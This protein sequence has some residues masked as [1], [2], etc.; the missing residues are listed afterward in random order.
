MCQNTAP[1]PN[2]SAQE[3][4]KRIDNLVVLNVRN[5][6]GLGLETRYTELTGSMEIGISTE[7]LQ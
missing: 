1:E 3:E 2:L 5:L 7:R 6:V 4:R